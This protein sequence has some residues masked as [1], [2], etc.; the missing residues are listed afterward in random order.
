MEYGLDSSKFTTFGLVRNDQLQTNVGFFRNNGFAKEDEKII[1]W[2]PTFRQRKD[3]TSMNAIAFDGSFYGLPIIKTPEDMRV[4]NDYLKKKKIVI[5]IKPHPSQDMSCFNVSDISNLKVITSPEMADKNV[6]LYD[7]LGESDAMLTD[8]SSVYFD[9][10]LT[11]KPIGLTCDDI[12]VYRNK[13]GFS[14]DNYEDTTFEGN[15]KGSHI[16]TVDDLLKFLD[17]VDE[18]YVSDEQKKAKY[19]FNKFTDFKSGD[20]LYAYMKEKFGL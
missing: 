2:L 11:D 7:V 3:H 10:L 6:Q 19:T 4:V 5:I 15:I 12:V 14:F 8:Y 13:T 18:G 1:I 16:Y 9:Y 17:Q 20:R